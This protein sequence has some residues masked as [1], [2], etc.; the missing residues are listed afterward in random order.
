MIQIRALFFATYRE[1]VGSRDTSVTLPQ[2]ARVSDLVAALRS[3][4]PPFDRLPSD[5]VVAV[6]HTYAADD[7]ELACGD[8]VA[9][10]P[11]IAGG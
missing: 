5:P 9:F 8:E 4:G 1:T 2:G 3:Q 11:P 6:N 10:I 7:P